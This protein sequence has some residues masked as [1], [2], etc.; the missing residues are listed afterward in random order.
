MFTVGGFVVLSFLL[1]D[2]AHLDVFAQTTAASTSCVAKSNTSCEEC[3]ANV[4]CLWCISSQKCSDYPVQTVLPP[5]SLCPLS[6]ARWG[7]CWV[8]FQ[9]LIIALSV[10]AGV[11]I[12]AVLVCCFCCCKCENIGRSKRTEERLERQTDLRRVQQEERKAQM[13]SRHE[14]IRKKYGLTK[15]NSYSRFENN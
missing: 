12:I 6:D 10:I 2:V 5:R 11:I 3:L 15:D 7:K 9:T 4:S 14:E 8:N 1:V 13:K